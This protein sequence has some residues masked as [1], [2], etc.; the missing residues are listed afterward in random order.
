M[1][2]LKKIMD[3][4][5]NNYTFDFFEKLD[6]ELSFGLKV[7]VIIKYRNTQMEQR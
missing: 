5:K 7:V 3:E 6:K 2:F 4:N 1:E